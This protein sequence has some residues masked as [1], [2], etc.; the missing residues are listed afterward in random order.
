MNL[1]I[2]SP[3]EYPVLGG[4]PDKVIPDPD[5]SMAIIAED[6]GGLAGRIFVFEV[7]HLEGIWVRPDKR[8]SLLMA[9]LVAMAQN[10]LSKFGA[11]KV[12]AYAIDSKMEDYID[13]LG[14]K[15]SEMTVWE[16]EI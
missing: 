15:Q 9:R 8:G 14:F 13:R 3:E 2:L 11:K 16:K 1:R 5:K 6:D 10:R 4:F 7:P 12:F